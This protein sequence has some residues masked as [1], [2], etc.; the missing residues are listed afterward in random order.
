MNSNP[1][2]GAGKRCGSGCAEGARSHEL[3]AQATHEARNG[4]LDNALALL[5]QADAVGIPASA[6]TLDL[7]AKIYAQMGCLLEAERAWIEALQLDGS[8]PRYSRALERLRR[9]SRRASRLPAVMGVVAVLIIMVLLTKQ[10]GR[11]SDEL[12]KLEALVEQAEH[13]LQARLTDGEERLSAM[14]EHAVSAQSEGFENALSGSR[15]A[16]DS[17]TADIVRVPVL[18]KHLADLQAALESQDRDWN[19]RETKTRRQ[20]DLQFS[21]YGH[22]LAEIQARIDELPVRFASASAANRHTTLANYAEMDSPLRVAL[23]AVMGSAVSSPGRRAATSDQ[24][25]QSGNVQP[26]TSDSDA[27]TAGG[28]SSLK[29]K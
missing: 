28:V 23:R 12:D 27:I 29:T 4:G 19:Q 24:L 13:G 5:D 22:V 1:I 21:E 11:Q 9:R 7:R 18:E 3:L 17:A 10:M 20:L 8:N 6:S 14:I 15:L 16:L 26:Q 2:Y 25:Y